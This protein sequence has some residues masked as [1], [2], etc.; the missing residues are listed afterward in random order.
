LK[1]HGNLA[2]VATPGTVF[3]EK[4]RVCDPVLELTITYPS[5]SAIHPHYKGK[6]MKW[7]R[8]LLLVEHICI[9]LLKQPIGEGEYGEGGE[10]G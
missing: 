4:H 1:T 5:Y 2:Y 3:K 6:R 10:K 9:C 8:S 7:R